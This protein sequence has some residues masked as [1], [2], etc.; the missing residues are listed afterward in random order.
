MTII[1]QNA[2][3]NIHLTCLPAKLHNRPEKIPEAVRKKIHAAREKYSKI[4]VLYGDCG[5]SGMLDTVL[6]EEQVERIPGPHCY[7]F[8]S[9]QERFTQ[10]MDDD[11][12][13]F[14]LTDFLA[15]HF[16]TLIVAGFGLER[17]PQMKE[18]LFG[19]YRSVVYL[20]QTR[21][22]ELMRY[23]ERAAQRLQLPLE[24]IDTGYGELEQ[25]LN[26]KT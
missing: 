15:R 11:P 21:N 4:L 25:F 8:F 19:N 17:S 1:K 10:L 2:L 18:L 12:T 6:Q 22:E 16:D 26:S 20:A 5:T 23:A 3:K 9:G 13:K 14:F 24:V 7:A